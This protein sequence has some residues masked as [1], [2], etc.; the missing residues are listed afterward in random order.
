MVRVSAGVAGPR[1]SNASED[2]VFTSADR[3]WVLKVG[4][5]AAIAS[6]QVD[7]ASVERISRFTGNCLSERFSD[8]SQRG[9]AYPCVGGHGRSTGAA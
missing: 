3:R 4:G 6:V 2:S 1:P 9:G 8:S 7:N 5:A